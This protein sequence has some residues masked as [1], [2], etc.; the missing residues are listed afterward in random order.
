M[1]ADLRW[2]RDLKEELGIY[3]P[4]IHFDNIEKEFK[5]GYAL[6]EERKVTGLN[7]NEIE[8][9]S[10][11][12]VFI[13]NLKCLKKV[14]LVDTQLEDLRF[15]EGLVGLSTLI[16]SHNRVSDISRLRR[17]K[18]LTYLDLSGNQLEEAEAL[19]E[20]DRLAYLD[21]RYNQLTDISAF[22]QLKELRFLDLRHNRLRELPGEVMDMSL[23]IGERGDS[24]IL[25]QG[26]PLENPPIEIVKKGRGALSAYFESLRTGVNLP[27]NE[28][29]VLLV[30]DGGAGKTSLVRRLLGR[31]FDSNE[32]QTHGIAINHKKIKA[33]GKE[34]KVRLW[35]FG[36]QEIMHATH[37]FFLS[38]RSLYILV[39]DGRKDDKTQYWLKH[40][41]SFGGDSPILI[42]INKI[43]QNPAFDLNRKF[44]QEKYPNTRS[45]YRVSCARNKG[46]E[47]FKVGLEEALGQMEMLETTWPK[48]WFNVKT[49]LEEMSEHFISYDR[50]VSLCEA[51]HIDDAAGSETLVDFLNDLG[52]VLHFKDFQLQ[53]THVL[54]PR[55]V[56]EAVYRI[57]NSPLLERARGILKLDTL[58]KILNPG[59]KG[60]YIYPR[61]KFSY[62]IQLMKKFELCYEVSRDRVLV[63]DLLD[64]EESRFEFDYENALQFILEYDFLPG[65]VMPRFIVRR[66]DDIKSGLQWRTGV[67]LEDK[68]LGAMAV[69]KED[70]RDKKI[71]I[72]VG[73]EQRREYFS[74]IRKTLRDINNS[75]EKLFVTEWV[76]LPG[77]PDVNVE[78]NELV[79]HELEGKQEIF[80]GKLR[81]SFKVRQLLD[82]IETREERMTDK[83]DDR[84]ITINVNPNI[85]V[86]PTF[87]STSTSTSHA[88][89]SPQV[90]VNAAVEFDIKVHLPAIQRDF[91]K[92][93][94][95]VEKES[96][97]DPEVKEELEKVEEGLDELTLD[98]DKKELAKPLNKMG[99]FLE[100]LGNAE[101]GLNDLVSGGGKIAKM[102]G[103]VISLYNKFAGWLS[104]PQ[105]PGLF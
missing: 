14:S 19:G 40:I 71:F 98:S 62:I 44:L 56:T 74:V 37:Q 82:G 55:W 7:L 52:V 43:D 48:G 69:I 8:I 102:A 96:K 84:G 81:K 49:Q 97:D 32:P 90:N 16:L 79:G 91:A 17:L 59:K 80:I 12:E 10:E 30:G 92:L 36:G 29:K 20:L 42:V 75:F 2:I 1:S 34:I 73:G 87:T 46:L 4:I 45:F 3:L 65:S 39:L 85:E 6:N 21:L 25:L 41:E 9:T 5:S 51:E 77:H 53:D 26:N 76:P 66:N 88:E 54:E 11:A 101:S 93:K 103:Q 24:G 28:V 105:I 78:Y 18:G 15:L 63:P 60:A 35:D 70:E 83:K 47:T 95:M 72:Y 67:V 68:A 89:A 100:D 13:S 27:L 58:D 57:I 50:Y 23:E 99:R 31:G 94:K 61:D 104:L 33:D 22:F 64:V 38:K 86:N